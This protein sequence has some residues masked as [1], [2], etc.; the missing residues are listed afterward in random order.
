MI[1]F[2]QAAHR[3]L[4]STAVHAEA[5][6]DKEGWPGIL[7]VCRSQG[8]SLCLSSGCRRGLVIAPSGAAHAVQRVAQ[9]EGAQR[10]PHQSRVRAC[11]VGPQ[12]SLRIME[13]VWLS[14]ARSSGSSEPGVTEWA[15]N[16]G[17]EEPRQILIADQIHEIAKPCR[18]AAWHERPHALGSAAHALDPPLHFC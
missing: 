3:V 12:S 4:A 13:Y 6:V 17:R 5:R 18:A 7:S 2:P 11:L 16:R 1:D 14:C 9:A 10:L 8:C 15:R